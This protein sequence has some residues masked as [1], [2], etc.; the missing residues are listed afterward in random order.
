MS[1]FSLLSHPGESGN[2]AIT[3]CLKKKNIFNKQFFVPLCLR[4]K[5][6][7]FY[8]AISLVAG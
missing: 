1:E 2:P 8:E 6:F 5:K 3:E 7:T 4:G